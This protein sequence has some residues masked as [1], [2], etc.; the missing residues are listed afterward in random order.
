VFKLGT[1]YSESFKATYLDPN[2]KEQVMIM[3]CYGI[4]VTRTLQAVIEQSHDAQGIIWPAAIAPYQVAVLPLNVG[5]A[6]SL[7]TAESLAAAL[8]SR[9]LSVILDDRDERPGFKF[10][11]ADLLGFPVRAVVSE[12][13]LAAGQI[14][15]KRRGVDEKIMVAVADA[16]ARIAELLA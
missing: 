9:G 15:I 1:K 3:G 10:K 2:G 5:H 12:R 13:S 7:Q 16:P 11:D 8:E 4:G 14:E 6:P